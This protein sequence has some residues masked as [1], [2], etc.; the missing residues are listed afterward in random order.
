MA[1][2]VETIPGV[3]EVPGDSR[4]QAASSKGSAAAAL[5][6]ALIA[7]ILDDEDVRDAVRSCLPDAIATPSTAATTQD[8]P[9][10]ER[11]K[12]ITDLIEGYVGRH[13]RP[14]AF[15]RPLR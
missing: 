13:I 3:S 7:L 5:K 10:A 1:V 8:L 2:K 15:R 14:D 6:S 4:R 11:A 9:D 12:F